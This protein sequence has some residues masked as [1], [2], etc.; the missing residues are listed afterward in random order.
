MTQPAPIAVALDA[1]DLDTAARWAAMVTPHVSTV[2]VGLELYLRYGPEAVASV[3]G[4]SGVKVFLDL[5]LHDIPATVAGAARAVARLRPDLLTVHAA[6]GSAMVRAAADAAPDCQDHRGHGGHLAGQRRPGP[7]RAGRAG[8]RCGQAAGGAGRRGGCARPGLLTARG[9]RRARRGWPGHPA[10]HP[11][12]PAG[13]GGQPRPGE[14]RHARRRRCGTAPTCWWSAAPS[15]P[16]RTRAR[17]PPPWPR[18]SGASRCRADP[19]SR[20]GLVPGPLTIPGAARWSRASGSRA[21][22]G[23]RLRDRAR[24]FRGRAAVCGRGLVT[25]RPLA[26]RA[27]AC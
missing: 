11:G 23:C 16:R 1:P 21:K 7:H 27:P 4:A 18:Q 15:P 25:E 10:G 22:P 12:H 26:C 14:G 13:R 9:G 3:R 2:K 17:R 19:R 6:G 8:S 5:K 24:P 20:A